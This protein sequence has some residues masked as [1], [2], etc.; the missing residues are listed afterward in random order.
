MKFA[1]VSQLTH[2]LFRSKKI[3]S[4]FSVNGSVLRAMGLPRLPLRQSKSLLSKVLFTKLGGLSYKNMP[5]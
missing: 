1:N 2:P 3:S 5:A 4:C